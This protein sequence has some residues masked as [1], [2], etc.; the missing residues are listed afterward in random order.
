MAIQ[1]QDFI[2]WFLGEIE[3]KWL[4]WSDFTE[5]LDVDEPV[6]GFTD[7]ELWDYCENCIDLKIEIDRQ[8]LSLSAKTKPAFLDGQQHEKLMKWILRKLEMW[9]SDIQSYA[10]EDVSMDPT[11]EDYD[12]DVYAILNKARHLL[13]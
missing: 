2:K 9:I 11:E 12:I 8:S 5:C 13:T 6:P 4:D 1:R 7:D 3:S 10:G